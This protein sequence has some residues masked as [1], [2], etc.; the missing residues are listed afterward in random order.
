MSWLRK[1]DHQTEHRYT[2]ERLSAYLD[3]ELPAKERAAVDR[4]LATCRACRMNL[5]TLRQT[6]RW[7]RGLTPVPLPRAFT[8]PVPARPVR[9]A[10]PAFATPLLRAATIAV[11]LLFFVAVAGDFAL[12]GLAPRQEAL[13]VALLQEAPASGEADQT[14]MAPAATMVAAA[15]TAAPAESLPAEPLRASEEGTPA[16]AAPG[17]ELLDTQAPDEQAMLSTTQTLT[18]PA[19]TPEMGVG[20]ALLVPET[21]VVE[22]AAATA[23]PPATLAP[24]PTA[25]EIPT[26]ALSMAK[27]FTATQMTITLAM[28][29]TATP[30]LT[31]TLTPTATPTPSE[32]VELFNTYP[33]PTP[34][35][36]TLTTSPTSLPT[37]ALPTEPPAIPATE[38]TLPT[39]PLEA[40]QAAEPEVMAAEP[41][42]MAGEQT[43]VAAAPAQPSPMPGTNVDSLPGQDQPQRQE[44]SQVIKPWLRWAELVLGAILVLLVIA[45]LTLAARRRTQLK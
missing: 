18:E 23:A 17:A 39:A 26:V 41:E 31:A 15:P 37:V 43:V 44:L 11:A 1:N 27:A 14:L 29:P 16:A 19:P 28:T 34:P 21:A 5:E 40:R 10:R 7:T 30:T 3:G 2:E 42:V 20:G 45:I 13:P 8:I 9:A 32:T 33:M 12:T 6:V 38:M 22:H 25:T 36:P 24:E 35:A 4:H